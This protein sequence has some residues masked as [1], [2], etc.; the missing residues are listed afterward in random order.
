M[1]FA[2]AG[3]ARI[4]A[5]GNTAAPTIWS[6]ASTGEAKATIIAA[7]YFVTVYNKLAVGDFV[8]IRGSDGYTVVT[9]TTST[10]TG[11]TVTALSLP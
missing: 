7:N 6:Y 9:V 1:A 11:L 8:F 2:L 4:S 3:L 10:S 5:S